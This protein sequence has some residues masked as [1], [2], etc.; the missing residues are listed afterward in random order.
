M[1]TKRI[2][3]EFARLDIISFVSY[4]WVNNDF[5]LTFHVLTYHILH[6]DGCLCLSIH[7]LRLL[8]WLDYFWLVSLFLGWALIYVFCLENYL[9]YYL[10]TSC[11]IWVCKYCA[12][13]CRVYTVGI[14]LIVSILVYLKIEILTTNLICLFFFRIRGWRCICILIWL[15]ALKICIVENIVFVIADFFVVG[16]IGCIGNMTCIAKLDFVWVHCDF[17]QFRV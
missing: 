13:L 15:D 6:C 3:L 12:V 16:I 8:L 17:H 5:E 10:A 7:C 2:V 4:S 14:E 9:C 11:G 1:S